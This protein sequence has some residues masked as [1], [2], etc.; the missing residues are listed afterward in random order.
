V[1]K[2]AA[3]INQEYIILLDCS[4]VNESLSHGIET[5]IHP[6]S[7]ALRIDSHVIVETLRRDGFLLR[8][9]EEALFCI[10]SQLECRVC[11]ARRV[12]VPDPL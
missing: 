9:A 8:M 1:P 5:G 12:A 3:Y 7:T 11:S 4:A 10:V 6:A 2:A